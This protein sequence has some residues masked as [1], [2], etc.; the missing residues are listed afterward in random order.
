MTGP[1]HS[2]SSSWVQSAHRRDGSATALQ[3]STGQPGL[4][5]SNPGILSAGSY[6]DQSPNY[7][8]IAV[9]NSSIPPS[10]SPG[11]HTQKGWGSL[12]LTQSSLPSPKL[13]LYPQNP[14][15]ESLVN[16]LKTE[17]ETD[18]RRRESVIHHR[19]QPPFGRGLPSHTPEIEDPGID[20]P[21][22][23]HFTGPGSRR[24]LS[25]SHGMAFPSERIGAF[26]IQ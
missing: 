15:S 23:R 25:S 4:S 13:Q 26:L 17:S 20:H 18:K 6:A 21:Q 7:F 22:D 19:S 1:G 14:V 2:P 12:P 10:S 5:P 24:K 16:L 8:G 9:E 11:P 3:F